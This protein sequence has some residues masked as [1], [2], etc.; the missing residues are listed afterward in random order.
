MSRSHSEKP[1]LSLDERQVIFRHVAR[2]PRTLTLY[3]LATKL[4]LGARRLSLLN[5]GDVTA[6]GQVV[7][8]SP[9][10]I[11]TGST[12]DQDLLPT[13]Q[14]YLTWRCACSHHRVRLK[15]YRDPRGVER[16]HAC[17]DDL[18]LQANPLFVSRWHLRLSPRQM[19]HEFAKH[20]DALG[21]HRGL[22]FESLCLPTNAGPSAPK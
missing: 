6:N 2:L 21:F 1:E 8:V 13:I 3:T 16:C 22:T 10:V 4:G 14:R 7:A 18:E 5:L 17:H 15:T 9:T 19:R 12:L 20:R 11:P